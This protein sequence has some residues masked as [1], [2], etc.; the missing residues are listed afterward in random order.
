M[1]DV[2]ECLKRTG[3]D[4]IMS[5]EAVLE[6]PPAFL[7][8]PADGRRAG[9]G[10]LRIAR[11]YVDLVA[12]FP[13]EEGGQGSGIKCVKAHLHRML[14]P[15]LQEEPRLR[16]AVDACQAHTEFAAVL[17]AVEEH[18]A[19]TEHDVGDE[20]L[21]WYMRHRK[22]V[23]GGMTMA[24]FTLQRDTAKAQELDETTGGCMISMFGDS[25]W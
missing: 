23:E 12:R 21:S 3:A 18:H 25:E 22:I 11:E 17:D 10:R 19:R 7:P 9:P 13:P 8:S 20:E 14:H 2:R 16:D 4:G 5:S 24:E 6:Y 15:D 1:D